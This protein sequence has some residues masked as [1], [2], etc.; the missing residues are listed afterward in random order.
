[1]GYPTGWGQEQLGINI[2]KYIS[3]KMSWADL[4]N[5]SKK[6]WEAAR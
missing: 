6:S 1:M 4:V 3:G 2:Q 5:E